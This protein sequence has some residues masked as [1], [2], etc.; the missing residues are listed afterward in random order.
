MH[1]IL[2]GLF[3]LFA[4]TACAKEN[5]QT[6]ALSGGATLS[7]YDSIA[8]GSGDLTAYSVGD[9]VAHGSG[10]LHAIDSMIVLTSAPINASSTPSNSSKPT[11]QTCRLNVIHD[12]SATP[13]IIRIEAKC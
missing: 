2:G 1:K 3:A 11:G 4:A 9:S 5:P 10:D 12:P 13:T 7:V 8:H 6:V